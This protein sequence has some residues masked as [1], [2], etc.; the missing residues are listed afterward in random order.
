MK[1]RNLVLRGYIGDFFVLVFQA[2]S[3]F[4]FVNN[5]PN[6]LY[7]SWVLVLTLVNPIV[8]FSSMSMDSIIAT[9]KETQK[10]KSFLL[11]RLRNIFVFLPILIVINFLYDSN[12]S[13][14]FLL[15][16]AYFLKSFEGF[17][18]SFRGLY[19]RDKTIS[20]VN[21]SKVLGK[22]GYVLGFGFFLQELESLTITLILILSWNILVFLIYDIYI[23]KNRE[24][25][26]I[27]NFFKFN[28]QSFLLK[29]YSLLGINTFL[30][31]FVISFPQV[32]IEKFLSLEILSF[33]GIV[34]LFNSAFDTVYLSS[35]NSLRKSY[36]EL[37]NDQNRLN[38]FV[39]KIIFLFSMYLVL[40]IIVFTFIGNIL[41]NI[42]NQYFS[43]QI[44]VMSLVL[45]GSYLF[46]TANVINFQY[47][48]KREVVQ[49]FQL[50]F[51]R[52][53]CAVIFSYYLIVEFSEYSFG[54][55]YLSSNLV[56]LLYSIYR[57][58]LK[59]TL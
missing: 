56:Y 44:E 9:E 48:V 23:L 43:F 3:I 31:L 15:L 40:L 36:S 5:N 6:Y 57:K 4:L 38:S 1:Y 42:Y 18:I 50:F 21:M 7:A 14:W 35:I 22:F 30:Q 8:G 24:F 29:K 46:Y 27:S 32:L 58:S 47:F 20:K 39:K 12:A 59:P 55:V 52:A 26:Q 51:I 28:N 11:F 41:F 33:I 37:V 17:A 25:I 34:M 49:I 53:L 54:L 19:Y 10:V 2:V 13:P 45:M 16:I